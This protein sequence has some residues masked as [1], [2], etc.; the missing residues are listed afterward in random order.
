MLRTTGLDGLEK[1]GLCF[2][3]ESNW[4]FSAIQPVEG[5]VLQAH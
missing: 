3:Q 4:D 2:C 5:G 1:S